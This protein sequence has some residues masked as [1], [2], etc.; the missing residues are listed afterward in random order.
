VKP[1]FISV[2]DLCAMLGIGRTKAYE[3]MRDE[4][5]QTARIGRRRMIVRKS[6]REFAAQAV[7]GE[8]Q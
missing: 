8:A 6:A 7:V 3:L 5:I 1:T 4:K 2:R